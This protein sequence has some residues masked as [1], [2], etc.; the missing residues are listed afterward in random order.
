M[1]K[2]AL[3]KTETVINPE[4]TLG[5]I[6]TQ[7]PQ[8]IEVI[9]GFGLSCV[10]C[11][12][13]Y[14]E[15][16]AD[17]ARVH[18]FSDQKI[19]ELVSALN[20]K[21]KEDPLPVLSNAED[22]PIIVVSKKAAEKIQELKQKHAPQAKG[23]RFGALPGGCSG[24]SYSLTFEENESEQDTQVQIQGITF[25]LN[26]SQMNLLRGSQ[27][28]YVDALQGSGFKIINPNAKSTCGCGQSFS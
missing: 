6:V 13:S 15:S 16:L 12:V 27:I 24:F 17:S 11:G 10:G 7:Y 22:A 21:I 26:T 1:L 20:Q 3:T 2:V 5:E 28:D 18:G 19:T 14:S 8:A 23:L 4:M 25:F 9:Q